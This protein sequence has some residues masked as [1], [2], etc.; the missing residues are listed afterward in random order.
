MYLFNTASNPGL[1]RLRDWESD[2]LT[3]RLDL[4]H[5]LPVDLIF[6]INLIFKFSCQFTVLLNE[7]RI[8]NLIN[9]G[10]ENYTF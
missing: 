1:L 7:Y 6:Y 5:K 3:N 9:V 10:A 4:I 2:A 8:I